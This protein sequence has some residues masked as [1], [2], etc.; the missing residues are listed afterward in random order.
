MAEVFHA[1]D[2]APTASQ[3][4]REV[5]NLIADL[6]RVVRRLEGMGHADIARL[7]RMGEGSWGDRLFAIRSHVKFY[8]SVWGAELAHARG[9]HLDRW[10][11]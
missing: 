11:L 1:A 10:Y 3:L 9:E 2:L 8:R 7:V 6:R 4:R 5:R